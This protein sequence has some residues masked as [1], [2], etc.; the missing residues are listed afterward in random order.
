MNLLAPEGE[1]VDLTANKFLRKTVH[2]ASGPV[3]S[4]L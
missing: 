4:P 1:V 2:K 3:D